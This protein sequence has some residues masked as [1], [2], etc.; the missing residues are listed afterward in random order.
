MQSPFLVGEK[1]YLR[2]LTE[3]D[4]SGPYFGWLN[5]QQ[6]D[7]HTS[8]ALWPNSRARMEGF[9]EKIG[10]GRSDLVLAIVEKS[11]NLHVGNIGLHEIN[12]VHRAATLAILI[13]E[14][15]ARG[16]G[17][18]KE[19]LNLLVNHAFSRL[20]LHRIQLGV[21]ADNDAALRAYRGAGFVVEGRFVDAMYGAGKYHDVIRMARLNSNS[22]VA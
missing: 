7:V 16:K 2:S 20:N 14:A 4:L 9:L 19:V 13:G 11:T 22:S 15:K 5:D 1:T 18:G 6:S 8:H 3:A 12:W 10:V 21:R 17:Y